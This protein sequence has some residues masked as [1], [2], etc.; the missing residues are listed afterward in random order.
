MKRLVSLM[1][2]FCMLACVPTTAP[3]S[4]RGEDTEYFSDSCNE[5]PVY[6]V[7]LYEK[8]PMP[9]RK[10]RFEMTERQRKRLFRRIERASSLRVPWYLALLSL[11]ELL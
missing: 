3:S 9:M 1:L 2:L 7:L 4:I 8:H 6:G 5:M 11:F 10:E